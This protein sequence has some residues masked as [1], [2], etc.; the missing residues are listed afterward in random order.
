[1]KEIYVKW[2]MSRIEFHE[3]QIRIYNEMLDEKDYGKEYDIE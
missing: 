1:M 2:I 3:A